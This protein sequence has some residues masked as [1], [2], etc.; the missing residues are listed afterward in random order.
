MLKSILAISL[1]ALSTS[2]MAK[3]VDWTPY[4]NGMQDGCN[5]GVYLDTDKS[6]SQ[7][8]FLSAMGYNPKRLGD[9][10]SKPNKNN[11]PAILTPS[12]SYIT[13]HNDNDDSDVYSHTLHLKNA[14]AFGEPINKITFHYSGW[15]TDVGGVLTV[16]FN[17]QNFMKLRPYFTLDAHGSKRPVGQFYSWIEESDG[18]STRFRT[19]T[20]Q[21]LKKL[22]QVSTWTDEDGRSGTYIDYARPD[23]FES[24]AIGIIT[25]TGWEY[26]HELGSTELTFDAK[27]K[28]ITCS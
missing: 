6:T 9:S 17:N 24:G 26:W 10:F 8:K 3:S 22:K 28:S 12:V 27:N 16:T 14:V 15:G 25:E 2:A 5:Y 18:T 19:L 4:L 7:L 11:I 20:K 13:H 1:I 23:D 21:E